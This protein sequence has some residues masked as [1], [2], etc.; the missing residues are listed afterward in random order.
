M[1]SLTWLLATHNQGKVGELRRILEDVPIEILG[2]ADVG[3][4]D[5]SPESGNSFLENALQKARFYFERAG[6]SVLADDSGLEVDALDGSPGIHSARFGGL[7]THEEKCR[8]LLDLIRDVPLASRTARFRCAAVYLDAH[9]FLSTEGAVEGWIGHSPV[10]DGGFGYDPIFFP[11][12]GG[13]SFAQIDMAIKNRV[14]HRGKAFQALIE[15]IFE[16]RGSA[17]RSES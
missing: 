3:I 14:S 16:M 17:R 13:A 15:K 1:D 2:L 5:E 4:E 8:Y 9:G 7:P 11:E 6:V 10:G 12:W